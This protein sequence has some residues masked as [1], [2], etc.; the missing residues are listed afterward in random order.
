[1]SSPSHDLPGQSGPESSALTTGLLAPHPTTVIF[2]YNFFSL[3]A[4]RS[5]CIRLASQLL[6]D[7][8]LQ[9]CCIIFPRCTVRRSHGQLQI[10]LATSYLLQAARASTKSS[11]EGTFEKVHRV[12]MRL[13]VGLLPA[14]QSI[15]IRSKSCSETFKTCTTERQF[16]FCWCLQGIQHPLHIVQQYLIVMVAQLWHFRDFTI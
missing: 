10:S 11:I 13:T 1:M 15:S 3:A 8:L 6:T 9:G 12:A 4:N 5:K 2:L 16:F 14:L 7:L